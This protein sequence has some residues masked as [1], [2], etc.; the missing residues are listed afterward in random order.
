VGT[1]I[2]AL[3]LVTVTVTD[4][5]ARTVESDP[6]ESGKRLFHQH[7]LAHRRA[8]VSCSPDG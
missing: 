2:L 4:A 8:A 7:F 3:S 1:D 5:P 6:H